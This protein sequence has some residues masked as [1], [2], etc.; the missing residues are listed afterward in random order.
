MKY[1]TALICFLALIS[2]LNL[3]PMRQSVSEAFGC[4]KLTQ[5]ITLAESRH[6][7]KLF[8][9][10]H[11]NRF[12][13]SLLLPRAY[14]EMAKT[15]DPYKLFFLKK[16]IE[17]FKSVNKLAVNE[18]SYPA[19]QNFYNI[20]TE[21]VKAQD[22]L[23]SVFVFPQ[24]KDERWLLL[25]E[26][27]LLK[28]HQD[29][30]S[31]FKVEG[32]ASDLSEL[33]IR[34]RHY[35][36]NTFNSFLPHSETEID[37]LKATLRSFKRDI[38]KLTARNE[39][40]EETILKAI[41]ASLDAH[42]EFYSE[43]EFNEVSRSLSSSFVGVGIIV[44]EVLR[45][46]KVLELIP[47]GPAARQKILKVGDV[48]THAD[49]SGL[50]GLSVIEITPYLSGP[51]GSL[52][53]L[54][55]RRNK[56]TQNYIVKRGPVRSKQ[57]SISSKVLTLAGDNF[58]YIKMDRF[59]SSGGG[60]NGSKEE[61]KQ[62]LLELKTKSI[63]GLLI[64]L[65][66]NGGGVLEEV[67]DIAGYFIPSG[68]IVLELGTETDGFVA[69]QDKDNKTLFDKPVVILVNEASASASE[70]L[71]G[72]LKFYNRALIVGSKHTYGKGTIQVIGNTGS[73]LNVPQWGGGLRLTVGYYFLP[74]GESVQF[75]GVSSHLVLN[76]KD[77]ELKLEKE[78]AHSLK[79]P[80]KFDFGYNNT[81]KWL[82]DGDF[83]QAVSFVQDNVFAVDS[84][85]TSDFDKKE[86]DAA[87]SALK[88]FSD[89]VTPVKAAELSR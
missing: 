72:S 64:D 58:G 11:K 80:L 24:N 74:D 67:I 9:E 2:A 27:N 78:L 77:S 41:T 60:V 39:S 62:R 10:V 35:L 70:I 14:V 13:K 7:S 26:L 3:A 32:W 53:N 66:N 20:K 48:I 83:K 4:E 18:V 6:V 21:F 61:F 30:K 86:L 15:L 84:N 71:A 52:V 22:R 16:D 56:T 50:A 23:K 28:Q 33:S 88:T 85:N 46:Y 12:N 81:S 51:R 37:A 38:E 49:G 36:L 54:R 43:H 17:K 89:Y 68:P 44:T 34:V 29:D 75:D 5:Y 55:V 59:F 57:K 25:Q 79:P 65:R 40:L 69:Y 42:S 73:V 63:K 1:F 76:D 87:L 31:I 45:G 82:K 47:G 19:C 8:P